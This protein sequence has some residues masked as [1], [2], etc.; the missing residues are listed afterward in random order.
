VVKFLYNDCGCDKNARDSSNVTPLFLALIT[1]RKEILDIL[2]REQNTQ[3][4]E[5]SMQAARRALQ[6]LIERF[7]EGSGDGQREQD[8]GCAQQ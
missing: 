4:E 3:V 5:E 2:H 1:G 7:H 6:D 8:E